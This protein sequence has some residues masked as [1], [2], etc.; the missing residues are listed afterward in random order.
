MSEQDVNESFQSMIDTAVLNVGMKQ[1]HAEAIEMSKA[2]KAIAENVSA[3][4]VA[5]PLNIARAMTLNARNRMT[6]IA[7]ML[8][9]VKLASPRATPLHRLLDGIIQSTEAGLS[10]EYFNELL[11]G[12]EKE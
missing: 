7:T 1:F 5:I 9:M 10:V 8:E 6:Q 3:H 2:E 4:S 12:N 11:D